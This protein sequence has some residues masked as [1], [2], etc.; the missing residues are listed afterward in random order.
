MYMSK[1]HHF[2]TNFFAFVIIIIKN[3]KYMILIGTPTTQ[4]HDF[5]KRFFWLLQSLISN[6]IRNH[7]WRWTRKLLSLRIWSDVILHMLMKRPQ[8]VIPPRKSMI[9]HALYSCD[10]HPCSAFHWTHDLILPV[11]FLDSESN[12]IW[13]FPRNLGVLF[14]GFAAVDVRV[15]LML[16]VGGCFIWGRW[17]FYFIK[18]RQK[19]RVKQCTAISKWFQKYLRRSAPGFGMS[20]QLS[21][22]TFG[23]L[24]RNWDKQLCSF[25]W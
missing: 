8:W 21:L 3:G 14:S 9:F 12:P 11:F 23:A 19:R 13:E 22:I 20:R 1:R 25:V 15:F 17:G 10:N 18:Q 6:R 7:G 2:F 24:P 16:W 4:I 5:S